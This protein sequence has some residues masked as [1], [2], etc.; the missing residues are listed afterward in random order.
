MYTTYLNSELIIGSYD[1]GR[2]S[3]ILDTNAGLGVEN[4][5]IDLMYES[6]DDTFDIFII[7]GYQIGECLQRSILFDKKLNVKLVSD[8]MKNTKKVLV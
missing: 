8:L 7:H 1:K 4:K 5:I 2:S 6:Y 3:S